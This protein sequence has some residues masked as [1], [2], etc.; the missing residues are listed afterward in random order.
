M[1]GNRVEKATE[2]SDKKNVNT[3]KLKRKMHCFFQVKGKFFV[4]HRRMKRG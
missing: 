1:E 4:R 2:V 3:K